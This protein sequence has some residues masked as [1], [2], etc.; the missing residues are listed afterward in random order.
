[1]CSEISEHSE[2]S[3]LL[4]DA[5]FLSGVWQLPIGEWLVWC[6]GWKLGLLGAAALS[7]RGFKVRVLR[8][9][10]GCAA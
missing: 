8:W 7:A 2:R 3:G 9:R 10:S 5:R 1:M 4:A 6:W